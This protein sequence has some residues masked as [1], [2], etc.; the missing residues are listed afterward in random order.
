VSSRSL[1]HR[2]FPPSKP[3]DGG[4]PPSFRSIVGGTQL[5]GSWYL[6]AVV[7]LQGFSSC[8]PAAPL[9]RRSPK[10]VTS[11]PWMGR[12]KPSCDLGPT[13][14]LKDVHH[15]RWGGGQV[16]PELYLPRGFVGRPLLRR[17]R[18]RALTGPAGGSD[19]DNA[20]WSTAGVVSLSASGSSAW[21]PVPPPAGRRLPHRVHGRTAQDIARCQGGVRVLGRFYLCTGT[22][23]PHGGWCLTR[24]GGSEWGSAGGLTA[25][26]VGAEVEAA[27]EVPVADGI[28]ATIRA[29]GLQLFV[30]VLAPR[31]SAW[32][33]ARLQQHPP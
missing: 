19:F 14:S 4:Y 25:P 29:S 23:P 3:P 32:A 8:S 22:A 15:P 30:L 21:L 11:S 7:R 6:S 33:R 28:T 17:S 12:G 24:P 26:V 1:M 2:V 10:A 5:C 20:G 13:L 18:E 27:R 31:A 9:R 16:E